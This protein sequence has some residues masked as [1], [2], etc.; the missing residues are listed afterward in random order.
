M[1]N[2]AIGVFFNYAYDNKITLRAMTAVFCGVYSNRT[3]DSRLSIMVLALQHMPERGG[4][5]DTCIHRLIGDRVIGDRVASGQGKVSEKIFFRVSEKSSNFVR[6]QWRIRFD[7][8][9]VKSQW[10]WKSDKNNAE[11]HYSYL[12]MAMAVFFVFALS[13]MPQLVPDIIFFSR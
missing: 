6:S 2:N 8:K 10:I 12:I 13:S 1:L 3:P 5:G 7:L 4:E 9:S 11:N